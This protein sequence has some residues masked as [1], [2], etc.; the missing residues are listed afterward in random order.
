MRMT[1]TAED[2]V[3]SGTPGRPLSTELSEQLLSVAVDILA[4]EGWGRLNSDR[5]AARARAGKAGIYRRWPTMAALARHAR[6]GRFRLV[7]RPRTPARCAA[8]C[9]PAPPLDA[10]AGPR[11]ARRGQHRGRRPAR[12][13]AARRA[14]RRRWCGRWSRRR[15]RDRRAGRP[16]GARRS[17]PARLALLGSVLEAFWWQR[18]TAAGDGAMTSPTGGAR[19]RRRAAAAGRPRGQPSP[20]GRRSAG[21]AALPAS[22]AHRR[23]TSPS[24]VATSSA[25]WPAPARRAAGLGRVPRLGTAAGAPDE[26]AGGGQHRGGGE[27]REQPAGSV[28]GRRAG[29]RRRSAPGVSSA[30]SRCSAW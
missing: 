1:R 15:V 10:A 28:G 9:R 2:R 29:H 14:G 27:R 26:H 24:K 7:R 17:T 18:F 16:R 4:D 19:G 20:P 5:V 6:S 30:R 23:S 11:G 12:R 21:P 25:R 3:V 8:T 22:A 13:G